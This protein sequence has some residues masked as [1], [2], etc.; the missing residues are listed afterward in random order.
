MTCFRGL[1][2]G[3]FGNSNCYVVRK[4][5]CVFEFSEFKKIFSDISHLYDTDWINRWKWL[6]VWLQTI[7]REFFIGLIRNWNGYGLR[8]LNCVFWIFW[9]QKNSFWHFSFIRY[10]LDKSMEMAF[11]LTAN[12]FKRVF[13]WFNPQLKRIWIEKTKLC[14]LNFLNSKNFF[15][16]FLLIWCWCDISIKVAFWLIENNSEEWFNSFFR[17]SNRYVVRKLNCVFWIFWIQKTFSDISY[18]Y[19][20]DVI[21]RSKWLLVWSKTNLEEW[22]NSFF[23]QFKQICSPKTKLCFLNFLNSKNFFWHFLLIWC[24]CDI[25]IKVA[26]CLIENQF[27]RVV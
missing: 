21:Y 13:Y 20:A 23:P 17:N 1:F 4:L 10:W 19:D 12:F 7:S 16:Q 11:C 3:L 14:F 22:F 24:W 8:K 5:T 18:W 6:S 25:S 27:R 2:S 9:I 26:F 15:W